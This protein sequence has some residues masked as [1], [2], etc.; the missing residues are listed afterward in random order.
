MFKE[1]YLYICS[2]LDKRCQ[3][4]WK[5]MVNIEDRHPYI[6]DNLP[7][8]QMTLH[9][10]LSSNSTVA[11][12]DDMCPESPESNPDQEHQ[13]THPDVGTNV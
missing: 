12:K 13:G 6:S 8:R 5:Q 1:R 7:T 2:C 11:S 10:G 3:S 9:Y 4:C